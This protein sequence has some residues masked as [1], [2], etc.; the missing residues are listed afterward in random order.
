MPPSWWGA[1]EAAFPSI[2]GFAAGSQETNRD[3]KSFSLAEAHRG[4]TKVGFLL[5]PWHQRQGLGAQPG[6][7]SLPREA[8]TRSDHK[9]APERLVKGGGGQDGGREGGREPRAVEA[10]GAGRKG[11]PPTGKGC[12]PA[13][14]CCC[15]PRIALLCSFTSQGKIGKTPACLRGPIAQPWTRGHLEGSGR[16]P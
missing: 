1:Q 6:S 7:C 2:L 5:Y 9:L 4:H 8:C 12:P 14:R 3:S 16:L 11:R 15:V 10:W 13:S